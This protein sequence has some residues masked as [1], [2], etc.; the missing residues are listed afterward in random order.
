MPSLGLITLN[1]LGG[2]DSVLIPSTP[3]YL[4]VKGLELL[5][6]TI[7][8]VKKRINPSISF[9]GILLTMFDIRMTTKE[10]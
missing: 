6:K 7:F 10:R 9:E 4:S 8:K 1:V 2:C 3:E 5:L